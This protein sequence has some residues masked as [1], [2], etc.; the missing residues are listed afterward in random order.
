[1][2]R[3]ASPRG[4]IADLVTPIGPGGTLDASGLDRLLDRVAPFAE[5]VLLC[6][7]DAGGGSNLGRRKRVEVLLRAMRRVQG[8]LAL[9][10][11]ITGSTQEETASML[12]TL[13]KASEGEGYDGPLFWLNT[14]LIYH[15]NRGLPQHCRDLTS[16]A[17]RPMLL[18]NDPE[19]VK[20]AA[21][22]MKRANIRTAVLKEAAHVEGVCG[23]VFRGAMDRVRNYQKAV[24]F[25][26]DFRIYDGD[27]E[28]FLAHPSRHGVLSAGANLA[29]AAW[30]RIT[31]ASL[32][33]HGD[34]QAY[35][36]QLKG[37]WELGRYLE[38]LREAYAKTPSTLILG[39]LDRAGVLGQNPS[40]NPSDAGIEADLQRLLELMRRQGDA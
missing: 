38:A 6:G 31:H 20:Q 10:V 40:A 7:P 36:D 13:E 21:R 25:R 3:S 9:V 4:L 12:E 2:A 26:S 34:V 24:R 28:A 17:S 5:G 22:P 16:F 19:R 30:R 1:M 29:P 39:A 8:R 18:F 35:P 14:P 32:G 37:L 23:V 27:E 15:S 33:L 11:W